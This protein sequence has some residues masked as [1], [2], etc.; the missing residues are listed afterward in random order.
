MKINIK[1]KRVYD[2]LE[3]T[4]GSRILIDRLWPR[5]VTKEKAAI[6]LWA[7]K[8]APSSALRIWFGHS[9]ER[10]DEFQLKYSK[11]LHSNQEGVAEI[12]SH[13]SKCKNAT[14]VLATKTEKYNHA[15]VL[16]NF[17]LKF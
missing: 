13:L 11:E 10:W 12:T 4:D 9:P 7:K 8:V 1:I 15:L 16:K 6:D 5:G 2:A 3:K 14:L 17:L